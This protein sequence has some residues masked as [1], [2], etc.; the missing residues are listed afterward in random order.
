MSKLDEVQIEELKAQDKPYKVY[1]GHG[2][3]LYVTPNGKKTF[4]KDYRY[5]GKPRT[6]T[7]GTYPAISLELARKNSEI[8]MLKLA[9]GIDPAEEKRKLRITGRK[10]NP[11]FENYIKEL[12]KATNISK[13]RNIS[14]T[15]IDEL[16]DLIFEMPRAT[17]TMVGI[18]TNEFKISEDDFLALYESLENERFDYKRKC[19]QVINKY[20]AEKK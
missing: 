5:Y 10:A 12:D 15:F 9:D 14:T 19:L 8:I 13:K 16:D 6:I 7:L 18:L 17:E 11:Y 2:L 4:R 20:I 3:F 1:D